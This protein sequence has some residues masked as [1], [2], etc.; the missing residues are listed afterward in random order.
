MLADTPPVPLPRDCD[1]VTP[2]GR[3]ASCCLYGYV[4]DGATTVTGALVTVESPTGSLTATTR[5]GVAS[6]EPYYRIDL[7]ADPLSAT[8][9]MPLT[10]TVV[11]GSLRAQRAWTVQAS[12]QQVDVGLQLSD[13]WQEI[14]EGS[15]SQG[16]ISQ[17]DGYSGPVD[18][19]AGP[20]G[21][22]YVAWV[23]NTIG[24][25]EVYVKRWNGEIWEEVGAGS[26]FGE[27]ISD[28]SGDAGR[29]SIAVAPGTAPFE[30]GI[31]YV[32]WTDTTSGLGRIYVRRFISETW[33][34]VGAGSASGAGVISD[35][36]NGHSHGTQQ[37]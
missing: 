23:D 29:V 3:L 21:S 31:P 14:G 10:I 7:T 8:V 15:A 37:M 27:G 22:I 30:E 33:Q 32:A 24:N 11:Y 17:N 18:I 28:N 6:T 34:V 26:A 4:Y 9:G 16:G 35:P 20:D 5:S 25:K 2:P 13:R 19:A 12:G 36:P 1:D